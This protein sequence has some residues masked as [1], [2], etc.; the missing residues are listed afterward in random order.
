MMAVIYGG[1]GMVV[2]EIS[3]RPSWRILESKKSITG[4]SM[5]AMFRRLSVIGESHGH[6]PDAFLL[7]ESDWG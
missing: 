4:K 3:T 2:T 5:H 1:I 6:E 7:F